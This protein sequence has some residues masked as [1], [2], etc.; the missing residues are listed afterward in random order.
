MHWESLVPES[1]HNQPVRD[2]HK[3]PN[4]FGA[5]TLASDNELAGVPPGFAKCH[6]AERPNKVY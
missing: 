6:N 1:F 3:I 5:A 2:D 4:R